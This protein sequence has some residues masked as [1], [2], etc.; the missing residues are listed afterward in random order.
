MEKP[1]QCQLFTFADKP[2]VL[3]VRKSY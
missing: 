1:Q 2:D 3:F